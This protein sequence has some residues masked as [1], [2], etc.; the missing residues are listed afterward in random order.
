M[1]E[2]LSVITSIPTGL[3]ILLKDLDYLAQIPRGMKP[4][5]NTRDFV[6]DSTWS[7]WFYRTFI[8]KE[9]RKDVLSEVEKII[10]RAVDSIKNHKESDYIKVI[11]KYFYKAR[12]GVANLL[13]TYKGSP[14][15]ISRINV[16]LTNMDIQIER[17]KKHIDGY[18]NENNISSENKS[19]KLFSSFAPPTPPPTP[20]L[21]LFDIESN[22]STPANVKKVKKQLK[23]KRST[24]VN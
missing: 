24:D 20:K 3:Q 14:D 15:I 17:Y 11:I 13:T 22:P 10:E 19:E 12:T 5:V 8:V 23:L 2:N 6:D 7:G 18:K 16:Q 21:D 9:G 1:E 4:C